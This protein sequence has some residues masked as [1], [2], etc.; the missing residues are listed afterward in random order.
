MQMRRQTP[1]QTLLLLL[2]A[3]SFLLR[4]ASSCDVVGDDGSGWPG[5]P[6]RQGC[7]GDTDPNQLT[8]CVGDKSTVTK[9]G[10]I[11]SWDVTSVKAASISLLVYTKDKVGT[12][13][14]YGFTLTCVNTVT[15]V[16]ADKS[17]EHF[18]I[19]WLSRC[20][21]Q[22]GDV[23]GFWTKD[24]GVIPFENG[25]AKYG[26]VSQVSNIGEL[27]VGQAVDFKCKACQK[28]KSIPGE[29]SHRGYAFAANVCAD[30]G[31]GE[32]ILFPIL[33]GVLF[34]EIM[35][36]VAHG[37]RNGQKVDAT[38]KIWL[39][40]K[41]PHRKFVQKELPSLVKDGLLFVKSGGMRRAYEPVGSVNYAV[42][43]TVEYFS[44]SKK[45]WKKAKVKKVHKK[46]GLIDLDI[47]A[48]V[49]GDA[50]R[51]LSVVTKKVV[52][53]KAMK[54][55]D[56]QK[57]ELEKQAA[58]MKKEKERMRAKSK[59]LKKKAAK[60]AAA[61]QAAQEALADAEQRVAAAEKA[62][63]EAKKGGGSGKQ[64]GGTGKWRQVDDDDKAV[65][66]GGR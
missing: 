46:K 42:G 33:A 2:G 13:M 27:K 5:C 17:V 37:V 56:K 7:T 60:G 55:L 36:G 18:E 16:T 25:N 1:M 43:D 45:E 21:V 61:G 31:W 30:E 62:A 52:D 3:S 23:I 12:Q 66:L 51:S 34:L 9:D 35:Y 40:Q 39:F 57:A 29:L 8:V 48:G 28:G 6:G 65:R 50:V 19:P 20:S 22:K 58:K 38:T 4:S 64:G 59:D 32:V 24:T 41:H 44:A 15:T 53:K 47:K 54:A 63:A 11:S 10:M 26:A 14:K 49:K